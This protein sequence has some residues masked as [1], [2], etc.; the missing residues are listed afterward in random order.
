MRSVILT[1]DFKINKILNK[2]SLLETVESIA[3][4]R[5]WSNKIRKILYCALRVLCHTAQA[6]QK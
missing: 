5:K 1:L 3:G 6:S 2:L 4:K